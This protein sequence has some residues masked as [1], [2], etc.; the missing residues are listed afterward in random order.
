L[1]VLYPITTEKAISMIE[2]ENKILFVVEKNATKKEIKEDVEKTFSVKVEYV[3][4]LITPQ[5]QKR[6]YVKLK[7][8]FKA[9]DIATK[10][11]IA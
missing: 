5:G 2:L 4:T 7:K 10:L 1:V 3:N 6:A 9:D 8:G 11:K